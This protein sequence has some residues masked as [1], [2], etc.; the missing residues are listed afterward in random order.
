MFIPRR[1]RAFPS[2]IIDH[3]SDVDGVWEC[4]GGRGERKGE[5][6]RKERAKVSKNDPTR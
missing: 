3:S 1:G 2:K 4:H 5:G 6:E